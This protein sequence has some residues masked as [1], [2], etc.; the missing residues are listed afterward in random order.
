QGNGLLAAEGVKGTGRLMADRIDASGQSL[1]SL[2]FDA[3]VTPADWEAG[4]SAWKPDSVSLTTRM[5]GNWESPYKVSIPVLDINTPY[6]S[7]SVEGPG[8]RIY[9]DTSRIEL[10]DFH[11]GARRNGRFDIRGRGVYVAGDSIDLDFNID[12]LD[13]SLPEKLSLISEPAEGFASVGV[14]AKGPLNDPDIKMN[15]RTDSLKFSQF[16]ASHLNVDLAYLDDTLRSSL[17]LHNVH[18]DSITANMK[19]PVQVNLTDSQ[20]VSSIDAVNGGLQAKNVRPSAFYEFDNPENQLFRVLMNADLA[21]TGSIADPVMKG[22]FRLSNGELRLP[23][24]G[25]RYRDLVLS[26]QL[27]SNRVVL[28][29]LF[30][31]RDKGKFLVSGHMGFDSTLIS[32]QLSDVDMTLKADDFFLSKHSNHEVQIDADT[33]LQTRQEG[34][35]FGGELVVLRSG[36]YLPALLD[37]GGDSDESQ[38]LLVQ[39]LEEEPVSDTMVIH[40]DSL[41]TEESTKEDTS[42][43][44]FMMEELTGKINVQIPRNTWVRSDDMN[45]ELYGDLD[46]LKNNE[47][48]E[49]FGTVG[50][51]RGFY[52]LYG[53]K[54]TIR[55]GELTFQGGEEPNP[56]IS[57]AAAYQFRDKN[58]QKNELIMRADGTAFEPNLSFTL[59][60]TTITER[61]AMAYLVFNQP[62]D[63]LSFGNQEG[64][65]G[66]LPS[67]MLSGLVSSQLTKTV[68]DTFDLDMVEI[69]AGDDWESGTV[70]VGKYLTNNLF[71]TYQR[72]FGER[73]EESLTPQVITLEY[74]VTRNVS[75]R[76]IQGDAKD[77]GIDVILKFEKE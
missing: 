25:V 61:D 39:V 29:S 21:V 20:M 77:S 34:P 12:H 58:K 60:G 4:L 57:L 67:A 68:G 51:S 49:I 5:K 1:D 6:E 69:K 23:A 2:R 36:F 53:R 11:L 13:L 72:G 47:Y 31:R 64:V 26:A 7:F 70:M 24:Y 66:N 35:V 65:S 17:A 32:G 56:Q 28:D 27:D 71:V 54:L 16:L 33:W 37:M 50:I 74:E 75:L 45:M 30:T 63:Q 40:E 22:S 3:D 14:Q 19:A 15:A 42:G 52:T 43:T 48:F 8:P 10:A 44:N 38:P 41:F 59:N 46:L 73:H 76:L 62:F 55:E 9:A 18:G